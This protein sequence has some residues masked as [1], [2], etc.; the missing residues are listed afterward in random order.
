MVTNHAA[1]VIPRSTALTFVTK[2]RNVNLHHLVLSNWKTGK[3][4]SVLKR[5]LM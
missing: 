1:D 2:M 3:R 4:Q 5:N